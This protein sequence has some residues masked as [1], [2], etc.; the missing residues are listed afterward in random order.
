MNTTRPI[1]DSDKLDLLLA[2]LSS[3]EKRFSVLTGIKDVEHLEFLDRQAQLEAKLAQLE[4][5]LERAQSVTA[6]VTSCS[7]ALVHSETEEQFLSQV[8]DFIVKS[9]GFQMVWIGYAL[10][11][12]EKTVLPMAHSGFDD[13]YV[14]Q[15]KLSWGNNERG[16]GPTGRCIRN[17]TAEVTHNIQTDTS[18]IPWRSEALKR[19]F[20][21]VLALPLILPDNKV[22]GALSL[23]SH[24][25]DYFTI[26]EIRIMSTMASDIA[27]SI[28]SHRN[29][30]K[31]REEQTKIQRDYK[32]RIAISALLEAS[33]QPMS[34]QRQLEAALDLIVTVP[35]VSIEPKGSI[36]LADEENRHLHLTVQRG[37]A[38]PLL[39]LCNRIDYGYCLCGRAAEQRKVVFTSCLNAEHDVHFEGIG[40]HGHFCVPIQAA[41][42]LYGVLNLYVAHGHQ[43][44]EDEE[45]F[46]VAVANTLAGIIQRK[47]AEEKINYMATTDAL[48]TLPNRQAFLDRLHLEILRAKRE[49]HILAVMFID[50][51]GF[52]QVNDQKG[53]QVGDQ[54]LIQVGQRIKSCI[55]E[56]DVAGRLGGDE[57]SL[58]LTSIASKKNA[59]TIA[60]K[61]I[62]AIN[63][64]F[65]INGMDIKVGASIGI[66][67]Y[68]DNGQDSDSLLQK[69]DVS[70]YAVKRNGR[71]HCLTYS[72]DYEHILQ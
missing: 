48:T 49:R 56:T 45:S 15:L 5:E 41:G 68:P 57:F 61:V 8:C 62:K 36:F 60:S 47:K 59:V 34:L 54:L 65:L 40:P 33:I 71:N 69:A 11:D 18:F 51:D 64:Q 35:W 67:F 14:E 58:V 19:G 44:N 22:L 52:K 72:P 63:K 66:A 3:L 42:K 28:Q 9:G 30:Q 39:Q 32:S 6:A 12:A 43:R 27:Y 1:S 4:R 16:Q 29:L 46:L 37:L 7:K 20:L 38:T 17:R 2:Q 55:R 26:S 25:S 53:H 24:K 13:G 31:N 23:Y 50:L 10:D 70:L 21:S